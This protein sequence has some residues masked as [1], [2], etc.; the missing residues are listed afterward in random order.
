M[1]SDKFSCSY[2]LSLLA[3]RY[4]FIVRQLE[5][6]DY[7]NENKKGIS[8]DKCSIIYYMTHDNGFC[9]NILLADIQIDEELVD[10]YEHEFENCDINFKCV[11]KS[12]ENSSN[13]AHPANIAKIS[14]LQ[15]ISDLIHPAETIQISTPRNNS[16]V[17][18]KQSIIC[19][20]SIQQQIVLKGINAIFDYQEN[21]QFPFPDL[22]KLKKAPLLQDKPLYYYE[23]PYTFNNT[24][25]TWMDLNKLLCLFSST[26]IKAFNQCIAKCFETEDICIFCLSKDSRTLILLHPPSF[27]G[28]ENLSFICHCDDISKYIE[29][30][31][32]DFFEFAAK[33][34]HKDRATYQNRMIERIKKVGEEILQRILLLNGKLDKYNELVAYVTKRINDYQ[35]KNGCNYQAHYECIT[36]YASFAL[37]D[38]ANLKIYHDCPYCDFSTEL[39]A[40]CVSNMISENTKRRKVRDSSKYK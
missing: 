19:F 10:K 25:L 11:S 30:C 34:V 38:I 15:N 1:V 23:C 32:N 40:K 31:Q 21:S 33:E 3:G 36:D 9:N 6:I 5:N 7:M 26:S 13:T 4:K 17:R 27:I 24:N 14:K 20:N 22:A 35:Y 39:Y 16:I 2:N 29:N 12:F 37:G 18:I 8:R 28:F